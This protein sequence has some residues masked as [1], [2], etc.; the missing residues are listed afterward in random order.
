VR[1]RRTASGYDA[2]TSSRNQVSRWTRSH[3]L[4]SSRPIKNSCADSHLDL[5]V[6]AVQAEKHIR[7]KE[8][9]PLVAIDEGMIHE[10][11]LEEGRCHLKQIDVV[12]RSGPVES[13]S[14][15]GSS[16]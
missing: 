15:G 14:S 1:P 4:L 3:T 2:T 8:G 16:G 5:D 9:D 7:R 10:Q 6:P 12:P 11:R 13:L